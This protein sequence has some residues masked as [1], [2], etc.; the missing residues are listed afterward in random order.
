MKLKTFNLKT[1]QSTNDVAIKKIKSGFKAGIYFTRT[2]VPKELF[3]EGS[4][5]KGFYFQIPLDLFNNNYQNNY[6]TFK[7]SPLTRD[8]GAKLIY[9]KDL[10]GMIYN[11]S[12][13][14][15]INQWDGFLN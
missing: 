12:H 10:R 2:D 9:D 13:R 5:D 3:G 6:T 15:L 8:G 4:F 1:T 14:E 11:S 7:L